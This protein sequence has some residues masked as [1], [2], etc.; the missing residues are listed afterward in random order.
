MGW[1]VV[2]IRDGFN[3]LLNPDQYP[4]G[5][6]VRLS[7]E[8]VRGIVHQ[9]GTIIGTTNRG[10]PTAYPVQQADGTWTE[11]DRTAGA[12]RAASP[13]TASTPSSRSAATAR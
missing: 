6:V 12:R 3:G 5:G 11:V 9:G 1:D 8:S 13:S 2:G 4:Q 7:R 10:N